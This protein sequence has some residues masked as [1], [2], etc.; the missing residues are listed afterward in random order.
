VKPEVMVV[1][2]KLT[3]EVASDPRV[4]RVIPDG[5]DEP[6]ETW[7]QAF[8][9]LSEAIAIADVRITGQSV[10]THTADDVNA[11]QSAEERAIREWLAG[12]L[13]PDTG[14]PLPTTKRLSERLPSRHVVPIIAKLIE[15][16]DEARADTASCLRVRAKE[17][18]NV[19]PRLGELDGYPPTDAE[20]WHFAHRLIAELGSAFCGRCG[21]PLNDHQRKCRDGGDP[22]PSVLAFG[23]E[24]P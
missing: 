13:N 16:L 17:M 10:V 9:R 24:N 2:I 1:P 21:F 23:Y 19:R 20:L 22:Q 12:Q 11:D 5:P 4:W 15:L 18:L 8:I 7:E 14:G 6:G 3:F